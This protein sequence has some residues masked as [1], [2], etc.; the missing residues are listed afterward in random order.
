MPIDT[1]R[2]VIVSYGIGV[3][4]TGL[5]VEM[6]NRGI[7][8]DVILYADTGCDKLETYQ[9]KRIIDEWLKRVGFPPIT[10]VRYKPKNPENGRYS[11]LFG[12]CIRN[13]TLPGISFGYKSCSMKWKGQPMDAWVKREYYFEIKMGR[14]PQRLIGYDNGPKD[15]KRC[16]GVSEK[17]SPENDW[18]YPLIEWGIDRA[19]CEEIIKAEGL[20]VPP[21][22]ACWFCGVTQVEELHDMYFSQLAHHRRYIRLALWMEDN[23]R[24]FLR[25]IKGLWG[26]GVKGT[27]N[28]AL[29]RPGSWREYLEEIGL[30]L[31]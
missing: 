17:N 16:G 5:L 28:P 21:K 4:S 19:R 7:R 20:P 18:L 13:K 1:S 9:Y 29:R 23:A 2:P 27:R 14:K 8:P 11:T 25:V 3:D 26:R 10:V 24:P 15:R 22:S 30:K 31:N 6:K 12:N